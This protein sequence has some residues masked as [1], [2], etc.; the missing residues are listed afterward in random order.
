MYTLFFNIRIYNEHMR[1]HFHLK[2]L[3]YTFM[4]KRTISNGKVFYRYSIIFYLDLFDIIIELF[5][6]SVQCTLLLGL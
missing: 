3:I 1:L 4:R 6:L 2:Y 5:K